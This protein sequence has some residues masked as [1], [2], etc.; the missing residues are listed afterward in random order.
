MNQADDAPNLMDRARSLLETHWR[1][2]GFT[3]PN[4]GT[5]PWQWLWDS[6]FHALVW[7]RL[8]DERAMTEIRSLFTFQTERGFVPHMNYLPDPS[9]AV[10]VWGRSGASTITQPPMYGHAIAE[11]MASGM[12]VGGET[13]A[14]AERGLQFLFDHRRRTDSGLI[15]LV[16]PWESG[17]DDSARWDAALD[18]PWS[19]D[20]WREHKWKLVGTVITD[21]EGGAI[22]N[23]E[24]AVGSVGFNALVAWNAMELVAVTG[25][26]RLRASA[27][28]LAQ[29]VASRWDA[30]LRTWIDGGALE[31]TTGRVRTLD[32]HFALLVDAEAGHA[33]PGFADL[34]DPEAFGA[35]HGPAGIHRSEP[36]RDPLTY[37]RGPTWPQ[38]S[39]L[40]WVASVRADRHAIAASIASSLRSGALTSAMA[41]FWHPDTG[42]GLGAIPQSWAA[43]AAIVT[44]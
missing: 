34:V 36:S 3:M 12:D 31:A 21:D 33:E 16:H 4:A 7:C 27:E 1:P 24:F 8:G 22:A 30:D 37:W 28:E 43:L 14:A 5:Y 32:A 39:Y 44:E 15:E 19:R 23:D 2:E 9:A 20:R 42:Q 13:V 29:I 17:C 11:L 40:L 25:S 6:A 38:M 18:E 10:E 26:D 35:L 41:E